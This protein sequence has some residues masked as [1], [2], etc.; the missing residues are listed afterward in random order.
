M[1]VLQ[2]SLFSFITDFPRGIIDHYIIYIYSKIVLL[3]IQHGDSIKT[4]YW[5]ISFK[6]AIWWFCEG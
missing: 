4:V 2:F 5:L 1:I 3:Q 6:N